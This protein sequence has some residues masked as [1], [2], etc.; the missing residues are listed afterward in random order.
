[1]TELERQSFKKLFEDYKTLYCDFK[2]L[3]D[4]NKF[5][6]ERENK[7]QLIEQL[8]KNEQVDLSELAKIVKENELNENKNR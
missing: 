1:M 3:E 4:A 5:L 6:R 7:L 8:F 2:R